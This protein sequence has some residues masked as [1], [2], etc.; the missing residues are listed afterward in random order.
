MFLRYHRWLVV[1]FVLVA[2]VVASSFLPTKINAQASLEALRQDMVWLRDNTEA[3]LLFNVWGDKSDFLNHQLSEDQVASI[4]GGMGQCGKIGANF[5]VPFITDPGGDGD[6]DVDWGATFRAG[7]EWGLQ[8]ADRGNPQA[9]INTV[10][11]RDWMTM[12]VRFGVGGD[13]NGSGFGFKTE[14]HVISFLGTVGNSVNNR[15]F[16]AIAGPNE[17]DLETW[18]YD[19]DQYLPQFN[20][21]VC[22]TFPANADQGAKDN[23]YS[24]V[25]PRLAKFANAVC[26]AKNSGVI[27]Q[28]VKL[29][30]PAFNATSHSFPPLMT[31]LEAAGLR[32]GDK[33]FSGLAINIYPKGQSVQAYWEQYGISEFADK[34]GLNIYVTETGPIDRIF[35][36]PSDP[37][38]PG[39]NFIDRPGAEQPENT[40][41]NLSHY[42]SPIL[43][44][45]PPAARNVATIRDSLANQGYQAYCATPTYTI[46]PK[47]GGDIEDFVENVRAGLLPGRDVPVDSTEVVDYNNA[48]T[49]IFRDTERKYTLKAD[50]EEFF[51]YRELGQDQY[52]RTEMRSG[53]VNSLL[54]EKQK[55]VKTVDML[56]AQ[57]EMCNKLIFEPDKNCALFTH[58]IPGTDY[59]VLRL[60]SEYKGISDQENRVQAC[61]DIVAQPGGKNNKF[62]YA[63]INAPL[64][65]DKAYRV[66]YLVGVIE[67]KKVESNKIFNFFSHSDAAQPRDEVVVL[68]FKIPDIG[69]NKGSTW[70][71]EQATTSDGKELYEQ[72]K[73]D[74]KGVKTEKVE[75]GHTF[76]D[77]VMTL[78]RNVLI[79]RKMAEKMDIEG[80]DEREK[81]RDAAA[82]A[83]TQGPGSLVYC[84]N[85][86]APFGQGSTT[87]NNED[88]K[89][90]T[91]IING[92]W[93]Y[94]K[95]QISCDKLSSEA[96]DEIGDNARLGP[97]SYSNEF[98]PKYGEKIL[99]NLWGVNATAQP[100]QTVFQINGQTYPPV[101]CAVGAQGESSTG[102]CT[103]L[104]FY[105][106]Y[107][108]GY[109]LETLEY[110]LARSFLT[111][112][113]FKAFSEDPDIKERFNVFGDR[114]ELRAETATEEFT[115]M[116]RCHFDNNGNYVCPEKEF[117]AT[118]QSSQGPALFF[119]AR[120]GFWVHEIQ[121][122]FNRLES[123]AHK[124]LRNCRTTEEFLL[125]QCGGVASDEKFNQNSFCKDNPSKAKIVRDVTEAN[126]ERFKFYS[127]YVSPRRPEN[128][129]N[130]SIPDE[131]NTILAKPGEQACMLN[132]SV[133]AVDGLTL[134]LSGGKDIVP[135]NPGNILGCTGTVS[136]AKKIMVKRLPPEIGRKPLPNDEIWENAE[137]MV[138]GGG[139][140]SEIQYNIRLTPGYY[141]VDVLIDNTIC[142][143]DH[144]WVM[145]DGK[146]IGED[147][148]V[149]DFTTPETC[150]AQACIDAN[151]QSNME[152]GG[153]VYGKDNDGEP[154][155]LYT[156]DIANEYQ[157]DALG[158]ELSFDYSTLKYNNT[159]GGGRALDCAD[160]VDG[161]YQGDCGFWEDLIDDIRKGATEILAKGRDAY[162]A[163]YG[164]LPDAEGELSC[165]HAKNGDPVFGNSLVIH[166]CDTY[167]NALDSLRVFGKIIGFKLNWFHPTD[168]EEKSFVIPSPELWD[169]VKKASD[170]HGCD[171]WLVLGLASSEGEDHGYFNDTIADDQLR[172][173]MFQ[174]TKDRW[175]RW[176]SP[177]T[178][179]APQCTWHQPRTFDHSIVKDKLASDIPAAVDTACRMALYA[180]IQKYPDNQDAFLSAFTGNF[181][182]NYAGEG[183][184]DNENQGRYVWEF[185]Q[186]ARGAAEEEPKPQPND[187]PY[188]LCGG[189]DTPPIPNQPSQPGPGNSNPLSVENQLTGPVP[190]LD[191][192]DM[193]PSDS[194]Y[195]TAVAAWAN[196]VNYYQP[197]KLPAIGTLNY[198]AYGMFNGTL[199]NRYRW[200][201]I[202]GDFMTNCEFMLSGSTVEEMWATR[203]GQGA[204]NGSSGVV[205]CAAMYREGDLYFRGA[206]AAKNKVRLVWIKAPEG[207]FSTEP[208]G[209]V[210]VIDVGAKHD[211]GYIYKKDDGEFIGDLDYHSFRMLF[212]YTSAW[213]QP[214]KG[215]TFCD[216]REQC[217]GS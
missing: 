62:R 207:P 172:L 128:E 66:A 95:E 135:N 164:R 129:Q 77:D 49:P 169:A 116:L 73:R 114:R 38:S 201:E 55:C 123:L 8:I 171:P 145:Q 166:D 185:W 17:P 197:T 152:G 19:N 130:V 14:E 117:T 59:T 192:H 140:A 71:T 212:S 87:C 143:S 76:W 133:R 40:A 92:T 144:T 39:N 206:N 29:L 199:K 162:Y 180:G 147:G 42:I 31:A 36:P 86:Q 216:S 105:L 75:S 56:Y 214:Q 57:E 21:E 78:T 108:M 61:S 98:L 58:Q 160:P 188:G 102:D 146:E 203:Q 156:I 175:D 84:L 118:L 191:P 136:V 217:L 85:G 150:Q 173:G 26:D 44:L 60:L 94:D 208:F 4:C 47:F 99:Q 89:A 106:V 88:V 1:L 161:P 125:D 81:L 103:T 52:S 54:S 112:E 24:C 33:C 131:D 74:E 70:E 15:E 139:S 190:A 159:C 149:I 96:V 167:T 16:Y 148:Y 154:V 5:G 12:I 3:T 111:E 83:T 182:E 195:A 107:P 157:K 109:D 186:K 20:N 198:Q 124:Y 97:I 134:I 10:L 205:G 25:A 181:S 45:W 196:F 79:P 215:V 184:S 27:P 178:E 137:T 193:S 91:D 90:V 6:G 138:T 34:Y 153:D 63:M 43:G 64:Y 187:F 202:S 13:P 80:S 69:T 65:I 189:L 119:G 163:V 93:M 120:L 155:V 121:K 7:M 142:Q 32:F 113:Q 174:I 48:N 110:V 101:D 35:V 176:V 211:L 213:S 72:V 67:Q 11:K 158:C 22:G 126:L 115:D 50:L 204:S 37:D 68:S 100:F 141:L 82:G 177:N 30:T 183:W 168:Q 23:W 51:G 210:A 200:N 41:S 127:H 18:S 179:S 9:V 122:S 151:L 132:M 104:T 28:N 194:N 53:A 209:P 170:R 46:E 2:G 165:T